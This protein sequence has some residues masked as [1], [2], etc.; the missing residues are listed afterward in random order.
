MTT[1][2]GRKK[3]AAESEAAHGR[4]D[5]L[6]KSEIY[7]MV[8]FGHKE[9]EG[10]R[11][12]P[13][14]FYAYSGM[15]DAAT[16]IDPD[17]KIE[18]HGPNAWDPVPEA[19][20]IQ[21]LTARQLDG[22]A[23]TAA[24]KTALD[25]S[26]DAAIEAGVPVINF[27]A[28]SPASARLT[29][30]GTNNY[31]AGYLAGTTMA[32]WLSGQGDM[33]VVTIQNADHLVERVHGFEDALHQ[34]APQATIHVVYD[35]GLFNVDELGRWDY[36]EQRQNY[37]RMLQAYPEI[38]GIFV[39]HAGSG[40]G[41]A[42]AVE[43]LGL[44]G[45]VQILSFDYSE[46]FV[47]LVETERIRAVMGQ[48]FYMMGFVSMVLLH[49][50]RHARQMPSKPDGA[51][52][53][54]ALADFLNRHPAVH[55]T[56]AA[57]LRTI[58]S[59][60]EE[61]EPGTAPSIDTDAR[62][63]GKEDLLDL[64]ARDFEDMRDSIGDKIDALGREIE[65]RKQA[66][67][68]LRR[69]N[70][71]L[72]QRVKERTSALTRE[73]Y[74]VDTFM[75]NVPDSIYFKDLDSRITRA[76]RAHAS[77]LGLADPAEEIG[78]SDFDFF[79]ADQARAKFEQE[80]AIIHT[81]RPV[82]N[83]E[84]PD[85]VG[86]WAL[87]TKMPLRDEKG[88]I[89]GTFGISRDITD[90]KRA[91]AALEK[92]YAEVEEQVKQRT[93]EL[94]QEVA[95]R[96]KMENAL[97]GDRN[98]LRTLIDAVPDLIFIKDTQSRFLTCNMAMLRLL[99]ITKPD[100]IV[101]KTDFDFRDQETAAHYFADEQALFQSGQ[102]LLDHEE[103]GVAPTGDPKWF[104]TTKVPLRDTHGNIVGL[105]GVCR[106]I[107]N[108]KRVEEALRA[109]AGSSA[110]AGADFL[111]SLVRHLAVVLQVRVAFV[112][113]LVDPVQ[114]HGRVISVWA[115]GE[116]GGPFEYD[117]HATPD[118]AVLSQGFSFYPDSICRRFPHDSRL[119]RMGVESYMGVSLFD[120]ERKPLGLL[121]VLH[122]Q[123]I[124]DWE[125]SESI[126][127][128][129]AARAGMEL[130]RIRA[131]RQIRQINV[132][133]EQRVVERTA[134]LEAAVKELEAFAYSV[135]H[136]LRAPL[137]AIDGFARIL[138]ED[139]GPSLDDEGKRVCAVISDNTQHMNQLI[140]DL[141]AFSRLSRADMQSTPIDMEALADSAFHQ[142]TTPESRERINFRP[143]ALPPAV[144]DPALIGQVWV[145]LLSNAIKFSS[146]RE[147][148]VIEVGSQESA[149]E[150]IYYVRD[151][152][153]GF[154]MQYAGKLFGVFQRLHS[155]REFE[156]TGVGL[157]IV[158]R[159]IHRHGGRVWGEGTVDGGATFYFTLQ[160]AK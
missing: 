27:D 13:H 41:A 130:E 138:V 51:W 107:T 99:G 119:Q 92:A 47:K 76:N 15:V 105:V 123:P 117:L 19:A 156:G 70:E 29:F 110:V 39:T 61:A 71:E 160:R 21:T 63:L 62:I 43:E 80:Q 143:G 93:A 18:W 140:H 133:L 124:L 95:E 4:A 120:S 87:T 84:E 88:T 121:A 126:L 82:L 48:E 75:E 125:E 23:V 12:S 112:G 66:E 141:L 33:A 132:E 52:R 135:S 77:R 57:K 142:L 157:A 11:K 37:I 14:F 5:I 58:I 91:Q 136:D 134:Q 35:S 100:V 147:Q 49:A 146:K 78:K 114:Q 158:Q 72:E 104:L 53:A 116:F 149:G 68:E 46:R 34:L 9:R 128:V 32:G 129:F 50:A 98:L 56:T 60:L 102:P 94:Q 26:I 151:N 79:P 122:D 20:A 64:L 38:R 139:Y 45:K 42:Q 108:R 83:L 103:V 144:G 97:A 54:P 90:L 159:V 74:V 137:R 59:Q 2:K 67:R 6:G 131:E 152:G 73:K 7:A 55:K 31:K 115:D 150:S 109:L 8:S 113:E 40:T 101:G 153:A 145:N 106:D 3:R 36:T 155:Q 96:K 81:G 24:H 154:D 65:V 86:Y 17:I 111:H 22:I 1:K 10:Q 16:L 25:S 127:T 118:E 89:I 148:A 44:Q 30:V 69:L 85:G 28:D